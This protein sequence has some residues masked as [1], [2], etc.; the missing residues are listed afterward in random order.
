[1]DGTF[2]SKAAEWAWLAFVGVGAWIMTRLHT[3]VDT[4]EKNI[5]AHRLNVAENYVPKV[6]MFDLRQEMRGG[7]DKISAALTRIYDKL[8]GKQ[9]KRAGK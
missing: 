4:M 7:F 5:E 1:M 2:I 6:E 3:R 8:D 9:D